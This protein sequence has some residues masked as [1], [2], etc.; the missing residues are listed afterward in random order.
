[1]RTVILDFSGCENRKQVH[2]YLKKVFAFPD[3]YGN[4]L[5]A[6]YDLLGDIA[7]DT[8]IV[9]AEDEDGT[10]CEAVVDETGLVRSDEM[11]RYL[12]AARRVIEDAAELNEHLYL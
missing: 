8:E 5:D 7:E 6:L 2:E 10:C 9:F 4:N 12:K 1:M 11:V 3:Y